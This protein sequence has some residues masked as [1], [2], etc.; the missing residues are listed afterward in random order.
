MF[1]CFDMEFLR[2]TKGEYTQCRLLSDDTETVAWIPNEFAVKGKLLAIRQP[3]GTWKQGF[4]VKETYSTLPA[5][6][7][8]ERSDEYQLYKHERRGHR[9]RGR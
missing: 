7:V 6:Q 8:M 1:N 2:V 9:K 3:D 5:E 4:V